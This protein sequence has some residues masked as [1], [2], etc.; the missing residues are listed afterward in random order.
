M[1]PQ[2]TSRA[3][4]FAAVLAMLAAPALAGEPDSALAAGAPTYADAMNLAIAPPPAA[5]AAPAGPAG[6]AAVAP[7]FGAA[8]AME[9]LDAMRGGDGN[10]S[11]TTNRADVRGNVGGNSATNVVGGG[12]LVADGSFGSAA[13]ISTVIQNSGSN[14][15]IQNS[16]IVNVQ[17]V[18]TP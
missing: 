11:T 9:R 2:P 4:P 5:D 14:V 10:V 8:L 18:P 16:T 13:G 17:F 1:R 12:N 6:A 15:L 3:A 7:A